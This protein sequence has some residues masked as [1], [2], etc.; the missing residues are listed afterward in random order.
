MKKRIKVVLN[1]GVATEHTPEFE[2]QKEFDAF[3]VRVASSYQSLG[4]SKVGWFILTSTYAWYRSDRIDAL[5]FLDTI[6]P[7]TKEPLGFRA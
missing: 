5:I 3:L 2:D 7:E 6:A 1:N 4:V